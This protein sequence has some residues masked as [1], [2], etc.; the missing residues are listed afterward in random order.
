MQMRYWFDPH[1]AGHNYHQGLRGG[2]FNPYL[3]GNACAAR[4][5]NSGLS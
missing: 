2:G 1:L 4:V 5:L 3:P